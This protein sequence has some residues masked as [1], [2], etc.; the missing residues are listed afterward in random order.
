ML[1]AALLTLPA[2]A[3]G[4]DGP[5]TAAGTAAADAA[6]A[7]AVCDGLRAY[8]NALADTANESVAG[9]GAMTPTE[10]AIA[11]NEGF[12]AVRHVVADHVA[13]VAVWDLPAAPE[14]EALRTELAGGAQ[15]ALDGIDREIADLGT[16]AEI[17]D[18]ETA[19]AAGNLFNAVEK[20]MS[21]AEPR[22]HGYRRVELQ[23]AFLDEP[24]C[25]HVIQRFDPG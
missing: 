16:P 22:I 4:D 1:A 18:D 15:D 2:A 5:T 7:R 13:D 14:R 20:A 10:R 9:I 12:A 25:D 17:A 21:V 11:I 3:C 6:M 19:G 24:A 8:D 23:R